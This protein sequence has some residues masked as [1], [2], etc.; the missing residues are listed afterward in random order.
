M[1]RREGTVPALAPSSR[2]HAASRPRF[3]AGLGAL[4]AAVVALLARSTGAD[5]RCSEDI[6]LEL[7]LPP[8]VRMVRPGS[9]LECVLILPEAFPEARTFKIILQRM[10]GPRKCYCKYE[11]I[12][13]GATW[14][15]SLFELTKVDTSGTYSIGV[16]PVSGASVAQCLCSE[17]DKAKFLARKIQVGR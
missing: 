7:T 1:K 17:K 3:F 13:K 4:A 11:T 8:H 2:R 14:K 12:R 16:A 5:Q 6:C 10:T 9:T 15:R